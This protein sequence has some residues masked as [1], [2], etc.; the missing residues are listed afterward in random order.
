M[1]VMSITDKQWVCYCLCNKSRTHSYIG[2]TNDY[3]RRHRQHNG[4]ISGGARYTRAH[5][6][7]SPLFIVYGLTTNKHVLQLEWAIKHRR[8][9]SYK[10]P[11]GRIRTLEK[12]LSMDKW[13]KKAPPV[14]DLQLTIQVFIS[15]R[16]YLKYM[17]KAALIKRD[18]VR[19]LFP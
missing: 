9:R 3:K 11:T 19:Y 4:E 18:N 15:K 6:P 1:K 5:R 12:L 17:G 14:K 13:T 16:R 2:K 7:W 10:G 8:V